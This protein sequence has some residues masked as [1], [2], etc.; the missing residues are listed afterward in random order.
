MERCGMIQVLP[1][2]LGKSEVF[3]G[4]AS[5][6]ILIHAKNKMTEFTFHNFAQVSHSNNY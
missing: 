5:P 4:W 3:S 1:K 2:P 6:S